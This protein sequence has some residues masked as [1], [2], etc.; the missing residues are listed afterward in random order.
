[1][2]S[3]TKSL[4]NCLRLLL[5]DV[6]CTKMYD[7]FGYLWFIREDL[8][9]FVLYMQPVAPGTQQ[10]IAE[11]ILTF[12]MME[13]PMTR[14]LCGCCLVN[15]RLV[16][17]E[18]ECWL[19]SLIEDPLSSRSSTRTACLGGTRCWTGWEFHA[20]SGQML[21][22]LPQYIALVNQLARPWWWSTGGV[23]PSFVATLMILQGSIGRDVE[24][25]R[26]LGFA[27]SLSQ[28]PSS[29]SDMVGGCGSVVTDRPSHGSIVLLAGM[30]EASA[31]NESRSRSSA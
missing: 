18:A 6:I 14:V 1:M 8:N 11:F 9:S 5:T 13:L 19:Q 4:F 30:L 21:L 20:D 26:A 22:Q 17:L 15:L 27:A 29:W 12:L 31:A 10:V 16:L 2:T 24:Q 28:G 7:D 23:P 25:I 3:Y